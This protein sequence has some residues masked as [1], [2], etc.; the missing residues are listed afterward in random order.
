MKLPSP[1]LIVTSFTSVLALSGA[2]CS[3]KEATPPA[4]SAP[5]PVTPAD[6][7]KAPEPAPAEAQ[8]DTIKAA[9]PEPAD[10]DKAPEPAPADGADPATGGLAG[11]IQPASAVEVAE[12]PAL[13]A[14]L[15]KDEAAVFAWSYEVDTHDA[16]AKDPVARTTAT[17]TC[18]SKVTTMVEARLAEVECEA[19]DNKGDLEM[20]PALDRVWI[21]TRDGLWIAGSTPDDPAGLAEILKT[22]A[23]LTPNPSAFELKT[24]SDP[25]RDMAGSTTQL[26]QEG[27]T[28]C[29]THQMDGMYGAVGD[30]WC[31]APDKGLVK[32]EML[33]REGPST[34][35]Y[36]RK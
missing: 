30:T 26:V 33:G 16:E 31:F 32:V 23:I 21:A 7:D 29:H 4:P 22:K 25:D 8:A 14:P 3:K 36:V 17:L 20:V 1:K 12:M 28:W 18:R 27:D 34:E 9:E 35:S 15:F 24:E 19:S 6:V 10:A 5:A 2:A 13:Y 11:G